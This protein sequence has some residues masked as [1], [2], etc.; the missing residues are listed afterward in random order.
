[1]GK[2]GGRH[3]VNH[4][5]PQWVACRSLHPLST[6]GLGIANL[7][8]FGVLLVTGMTLFLYYAPE[9]EQAYERILHI[10]TTLHYGRFVRNLHYVA[11]NAFVV[12][13]VLHLARVF[14]T[15]SYKGHGLSWAY[16]L[17]LFFLVCTANFTGYALPWDQ[18]SYWAVKVG[19][20]LAGYFPVAGP[21]IKVFILAGEEIGKD[22]LAR[23]FAVHAGLLPLLF[24]VFASLH[25]WGLRKEGGLAAP[26]DGSGDRLPAKPWLYRAEGAVALLTFSCLV[27]LSL[28]VHAPIHERVNPQHPPNPV[29]AP[30]FFVGIQE[31]VSHSAFLGGVLVP[32]MIILF[33]ALAPLLDRSSSPGGVWFARD[34][35]LLNLIFI[36]ILL[37]QMACI[38]AGQWFRGRN[39]EWVFP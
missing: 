11:A 1:M 20:G 19:A 27:I 17:V 13:S 9:Q 14:F 18:V 23:L 21:E 2:R 3:F 22:T 32:S 8:C 12:L 4:L 36:L 35:R 29:K 34:R 31:M 37:I 38:I 16:G 24:L 15:G 33:L 26:P 30:W 7:T 6:L 25:L 39:W 28:F 5:H 10:T